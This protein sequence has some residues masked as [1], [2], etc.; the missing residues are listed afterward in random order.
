M[1]ISS[2]ASSSY[3][4]QIG[5]GS[6]SSE[7]EIKNL[8]KQ[9]QDLQVDIQEANQ[10]D[11]TAEEKQQKV[12]QLQQQVQQIEMQI[13]QLRTEQSKS[14]EQAEVTS[15]KQEDSLQISARANLLYNQSKKQ[16]EE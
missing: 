1:Q 13:Q 12:Q 4:P 9:K 14:E 6:T 2:A 15:R 10:S 5:S 3:I 11:D 8:E 16:R 7:S